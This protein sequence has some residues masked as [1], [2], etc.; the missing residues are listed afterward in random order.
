MNGP[1]PGLGHLLA[2]TLI[3]AVG[4]LALL[5]SLLRRKRADPLLAVFGAFTLLYGIRLFFA[6]ELTSAV[7]VSELTAAWVTSTIT[8]LINI[9]AWIFF[10]LL[11]KLRWRSVI[12]WWLGIV[13]AFALAGIVSDLV[14]QSPGT[15]A[16]YPNNVL[17]LAGL[18]VLVVALSTHRGRMTTD[19]KILLA[20]LTAF[21]AFAA[22]ANLVSMGLVP[23]AW[24]QELVGFVILIGCLG[25]IAAKRF[26]TNEG[27]L[28]A[29]ESE[30][31]TAR[32]IQISLLPDQVP[33]VHRISLAARFQPT[34]AVA[35]DFYDFL[36][37]DRGVVG[38]LVADVSG[39]GVPAALI[40]SMVKVAARSHL[41]YVDQP[42]AV[43]SR[44]NQ[45]LCD[46]IQRGFVTA[47]YACV[48]TERGE[49]VVASAGHPS[50]IL[51][52][53]GEDEVREIGGQGPILGRFRTARY[54]EQRL[55]LV[56]GDRLIL[57]ADG[58]PE[59]RGTDGE[60]FGD[61][62]LRAFAAGHREL[63]AEE[64]CDA[65]LS[66]LQR[67]TGHRRS[68]ILEDDLTL[69]VVDLPAASVAPLA[70]VGN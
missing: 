37:S 69:L 32:Q 35:G 47:A 36:T 10:W 31:E 46:S 25:Y 23:W 68:L 55:A 58:L 67:W 6:S 40:A 28:A 29:L 13:S 51:T 24:R 65:L 59:A 27:Q 50:P 66:S 44:V 16:R 62:R 5:L 4:I 42:A 7:G 45:T 11:L 61:A 18:V 34:S 2:G 57:Y 38:I 48:D 41:E 70:E 26:F 63:E 33:G 1:L 19:L 54:E 53:D 64:F 20:G 56:G 43:L 8:Y 52:R 30:L 49:I 60:M 14:R 3:A 17:V 21:G 39:H 12:L 22:N 15:L 9:P